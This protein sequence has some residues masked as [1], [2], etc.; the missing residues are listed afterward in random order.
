MIKLTNEQKF[1][2]PSKESFPEKLLKKMTLEE[3]IAQLLIIRVYS[4]F[5]QEKINEIENT[6]SKYQVGGVCFFKGSP[7]KQIALTNRL[8]KVSN[9]PLLITMDA[10]WGPSMRLDSCAEFP[11]Q[12]QLGAMNSAGDTLIYRMG[13]EVAQQCKALGVHVNFA[14][15]I[16]V[17][18]NPDNPVINFRSFGELSKLVAEKGVAYMKGMQENG[19]TA[20]VKHFPGHGDTD[21]DS[22]YNLPSIHKS[23]QELDSLELYPFQ[24]LIDAGV[25]M[26]MVSHLNVPALD[27]AKNSI[28]T[29]SYPIVTQLLK[30]ELGFKGIV[31]TDGMDMSGLRKSYPKGAEAEIQALLAGIDILLLPNDPAEIIPEIKKAVENGTIPLE[32]IDKKCL[33]MLTLKEKHKLTKFESVST[34]DL[35]S[36]LNATP[37]EQLIEKINAQSLTLLKNEKQ[38]IPISPKELSKTAALYIGID[39]DTAIYKTLS[40]ASNMD[41]FYLTNSEKNGEQLKQALASYSKVIVNY[42]YLIDK[43]KQNYGTHRSSI[44]FIQELAKSND[45]ILNMFGNPYALNFFDSLTYMKGVVMAY[46]PT[47]NAIKCALQALQGY[48]S[49]EGKLPISLRHWSALSGIT[50]IRKGLKTNETFSSLP[51]KIETKIDSII[52]YGIKNQVFPGC[53]VIAVRK[54]SV[55]FHKCYGYYT[56][57]ERDAVTFSSMYDVASL[58]KPAA[59]TLAVMKLYDDGKITLHDTIGKYLSYLKNSDKASITIA[60]L[61][62]H[63]S[64]LPAF[65]PFYKNLIVQ[66]RWNRNYLNKTKTGRFTIEVAKGVYLDSSY[67]DLIHHRIATSESQGKKYIYSDLGFLMLQEMVEQITGEKIDAY[68]VRHFYRPMELSHTCFNPLH[69]GVPLQ[70]IVPTEQDRYFRMQLIRGYVHDQTAALMGGVCGNAGLFSTTSNLAVIFQMLMNGGV[71]DGNRYLS[72]ETVEL[73]T[74]SYPL[75]G[76]FRRALG[77]DTP[78]AQKQSDALPKQAS[79]STYGHLGFTG[80]SVWCDPDQELI[81]IFLSNRV[82]PIA[83]PNKLS[84]SNIRVLIHQAVYEGVENL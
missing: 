52:N 3:K 50:L 60:E 54:G 10:E 7:G 75:H 48:A 28:A 27:S 57:N 26:V 17:N 65:I 74:K 5:S 25:E 41:F 64:G 45:V 73:F 39:S 66:N 32:L 23:R 1:D 2:T 80:T 33:K 6:V 42:I 76:C 40:D 47:P 19:I 35:A 63:T 31:I 46:N 13:K 67:V 78:N 8:Q 82:Y 30:E 79:L 44:R 83:E 37:T 70:M 62:T 58:T 68:L 49:F 51:S 56:Y 20:C 61:L 12:M 22:H 36:K 11:R 71:Y 81:Y 29:L 14:P 43:P 15:T 55:I 16:D 77:F 84:K 38:I 69:K 53:Q 9:I 34:A 4:D 24:K 21:V 59:T 72:Q 18:N